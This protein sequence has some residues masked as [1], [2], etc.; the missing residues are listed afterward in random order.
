MNDVKKN[1]ESAYEMLSSLQA[2]GDVID[3]LA[4]VR[5]ALREAMKALEEMEAGR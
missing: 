5:T 1:I 4:A 3:L 2:S